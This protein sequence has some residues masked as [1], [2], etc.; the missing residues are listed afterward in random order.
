MK[1]NSILLLS[2]LVAYC[3]LNAQIP[4]P[5]ISDILS[6][7]PCSKGANSLTDT[8]KA[9]VE[10]VIA[11][12]ALGL[13]LAVI[14]GMLRGSADQDPEITTARM[15]YTISYGMFGPFGGIGAAIHDLWKQW[16]QHNVTK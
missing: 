14:W 5:K 9:K 6:K 8:Q 1:Y 16:K 11:S 10:G 3:G 12:Q 13:R 15:K 2:C 7:A 4:Q